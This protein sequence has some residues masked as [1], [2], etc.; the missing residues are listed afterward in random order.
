MAS[1]VGV[2]VVAALGGFALALAV[3]WL[4][5]RRSRGMPRCRRCGADAR[6]RIWATPVACSNCAAPLDRPGAVVARGRIRRRRWLIAALGMTALAAGTALADRLVIARAGRWDAFLI[7][8]FVDI[9]L[10][11]HS[12]SRAEGA[13][14]RLWLRTITERLSPADASRVVEILDAPS[15]RPRNEYSGVLFSIAA[16]R[17]NATRDPLAVRLASV[18]RALLPKGAVRPGGLIRLDQKGFRSSRPWRDY[19]LVR[20]LA[21]A[22]IPLDVHGT[23]E[24]VAFAEGRLLWSLGVCRARVPMSLPEGSYRLTLEY[25][26][27]WLPADAAELFLREAALAPMSS[28]DL[29]RVKHRRTP[30]RVEGWLTIDREGPIALKPERQIL[31]VSFD[32]TPIHPQKP[33]LSDA[34]SPDDLRALAIGIVLTIP[35]GTILLL[36]LLRLAR[37]RS[38]L[39]LPRC[40]GCGNSLP[41]GAHAG[42]AQ[43][44]CSEC[45]RLLAGAHAVEWIIFRTTPIRVA[46]AFACAVVIALSVTIAAPSILRW[47]PQPDADAKVRALERAL[48]RLRDEVFG[49]G[50]ERSLPGS[51]PSEH[52]I[53]AVRRAVDDIVTR[54][55]DADE[56]DRVLQAKAMTALDTFLG[57]I[58]D[59]VPVAPGLGRVADLLRDAVWDVQNMSWEEEIHHEALAHV[60]RFVPYGVAPRRLRAGRWGGIAPRPDSGNWWY[61]SI[62]GIGGVDAKNLDAD[63]PALIL[64]PP[65][66][67]DEVVPFAIDVHES[68]THGE[69]ERHWTAHLEAVGAALPL[70]SATT[71]RRDEPFEALPSVRVIEVDDRSPGGRWIARVVRWEQ[72]MRWSSKPPSEAL[73]RWLL[74]DRGGHFVADVTEEIEVPS[75]TVERLRG[76]CILVFEPTPLSELDPDEPRLIW[77]RTERWPIVPQI[78]HLGWWDGRDSEE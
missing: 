10:L 8:A 32:D 29:V 16:L 77:G 51:I 68:I 50:A 59:P 34:L 56:D 55:D 60:A 35:A 3:V 40:A 4:I 38:R 2:L 66:G 11:E 67:P 30:F 65:A 9:T 69:F 22:G 46:G 25:D 72:S 71:D 31:F 61:R 18:G 24:G 5:G 58:P 74:L 48:S 19:V 28:I 54:P 41:P 23:S 78:R 39:V 27:V 52:T 64:V 36:A 47:R 7:P 43:P 45:G 42:D 75:A 37:E 12:P 63:T 76:G 44:R 17:A 53:D 33:V 21:L 6:G 15:P 1:P 70:P 14:D 20:S 49:E 26:D 62:I 73:G 57:G 13:V